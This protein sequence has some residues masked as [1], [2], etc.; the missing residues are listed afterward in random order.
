MS[1][2]FRRAVRNDIGASQVEYAI[3]VVLVALA[4]LIGLNQLG[5][6]LNM[7]FADTAGQMTAAGAAGGSGGGSTSGGNPGTSAPGSGGSGGTVG[8][9]GSGAGAGGG[10]GGGSGGSAGTGGNLNDS[11]SLTTPK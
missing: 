8:N 5:S 6:V 3:L 2:G 1:E 11:S 9:G 4:V 7:R 10:R